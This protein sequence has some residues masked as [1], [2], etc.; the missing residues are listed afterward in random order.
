LYMTLKQALTK[1]ILSNDAIH[2]L[3]VKSNSHNHHKSK[4]NT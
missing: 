2:N 3:T 4:H 1:F